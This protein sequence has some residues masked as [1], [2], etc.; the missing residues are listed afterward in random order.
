MSLTSE[1]RNPKSPISQFLSRELPDLAGFTAAFR[2]VRP[3][4]AE[5]LRPSA[6]QCERVHWGTL[7]AAIDHRLRYAFTD[8][9]VPDG[10]VR[11]GMTIATGS[12]A[13]AT[14]EA[15]SEA[16]EDLCGDLKRLVNEE[17]T[18]DRSRPILLEAAAEERLDRL[19]YAMAWFEE[20]YRTK[21][22]WPSTPLRDAGADFGMERMLAA[23]PDFAAEDV[24]AQVDLAQVPLGVL[25]A[26]GAPDRTW[27]GP[28]F[29]GSG[30]VRG[31][32]ADLIT[33]G[34]LV[35]FKATTTPSQLRREDHYQLAGYVLL[36]YEDRYELNSVALYLSRFGRLFEWDLDEFLAL[37]GARRPLAELR[38]RCAVAV[39]RPR[40][41]LGRAV[42]SAYPPSE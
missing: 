12:V 5:A 32:D 11:A 10:A 2:S 26:A 1:L 31:A 35:E 3:S 15:M 39:A 28:A 21:R 37:F 4:D 42:S 27:T 18:S 9:G 17:R 19:C 22:L 23:V 16:V 8:S 41:R 34:R 33:D 6:P 14:W 38:E 36:D 25:R 29:A 30:D 20:V 13:P 24:A 7:G 40:P